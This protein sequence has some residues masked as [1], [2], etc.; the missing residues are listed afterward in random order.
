MVPKS[1][2]IWGRR[3]GGSR[4]WVMAYKQTGTYWPSHPFTGSFKPYMYWLYF[5]ISGSPYLYLLALS[6]SL[7]LIIPPL[8]S[9]TFFLFRILR[10]FSPLVNC[11]SHN[12][13]I[14]SS[15]PC[16]LNIFLILLPATHLKD[17]CPIFWLASTFCVSF[18]PEPIIIPSSHL[19]QCQA[20]RKELRMYQCKDRVLGSGN[21]LSITVW[22]IVMLR[23]SNE[24]V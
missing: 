17:F 11:N 23:Q 19:S 24:W 21:L 1:G 2:D 20:L 10:L 15:L 9:L 7:P 13:Q 6:S 3:E 22:G 4:L 5:L 12:L 8:S 16:C 18:F 14:F